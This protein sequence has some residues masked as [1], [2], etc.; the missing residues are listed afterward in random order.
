MTRGA[1]M[2]RQYDDGLK[3][4]FAAPRENEK[5]FTDSERAQKWR[6]SLASLLFFTVLLS[7]HLWFCAE[8]KL[9]RTRDKEHHHQQQ[10][11]Q[12]QQR[13]Q[14]QQ[15]QRQ[16]QQQQQQQQQR[17][18]EPSWPAIYT[19][20]GESSPTVQAHRLL[21]SSSSPTLPPSPSSSGSSSGGGN[22][23]GSSSSGHSSRGQNHQNK[24]IFLGNS[25]K[26]LWRLETCYPE[27]A[28]SGQ[29][30][31]VE[32][33]DS[34]CQRNW[35]Q[36]VE[37]EPQQQVTGKHKTP[38]LKDF[39]LPFCNSYTFWE[40]FSGLSNPDSLNCS[41]DVVL[42]EDRKRTSCRQCVEA[43]QRYDHHAQEKYDEFE[44]VLKKYLQSDEY[45]VKSCPK[46]CK[47]VYKAWLC[48][49]Y[50][51]VTQ[52]HCRKTIPCKQYCLEVQT[53]CPFILPDN[54]D[55]IYGGLSSFICTGLYEN[56]PANAEPECCDVRWG[57]LSDNESK[58]TTN[59]NESCHRTSLTVSSA[60]RLCNSRLKLCV[61]VLIL[62]HTVLTVSAAQNTTGL[63]FG[64][65]TTLDDNSTNEE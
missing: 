63:G 51:E 44:L 1:W 49:Q 50:F 24:A 48:S 55:V 5:P 52:F 41:L 30:F 27:A 25:T 22:R 29:C 47:T 45:S 37:E 26:P 2:C 6:L 46:D 34:V 23:G 15:Q 57:L 33:A 9:T 10:H 3:I 19:S 42:Q 56:F 65:I 53:R 18:Q 39:Y 43:Y 62:L 12:Q 28:S 32:D 40:L 64:S 38:H 13:Q 11:Q 54:D 61:L 35:S 16:Q 4:W 17:Q 7:D 58:G 20:M 21:S 59:I 31:I 14:E 36:V 60:S 8:A